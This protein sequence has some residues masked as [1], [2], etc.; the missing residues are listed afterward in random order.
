M[1]IITEYMPN[2]TKNW[3]RNLPFLPVISAQV[4]HSQGIVIQAII[5]KMMHCL[6]YSSKL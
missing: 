4:G 5:P 3:G 6:H 2:I 1:S